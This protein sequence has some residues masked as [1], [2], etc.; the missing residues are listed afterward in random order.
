MVVPFLKF[1]LDS[2]THLLCLFFPHLEFSVLWEFSRDDTVQFQFNEHSWNVW[3]YIS[4][5]KLWSMNW[6]GVGV[7]L[8]ETNVT[9]NHVQFRKYVF[10]QFQFML[11]IQSV[12]IKS[13]FEG[14]PRF[15]ISTSFD[16]SFEIYRKMVVWL[17][18]INNHSNS[19]GVLKHL[20][21]EAATQVNYEVIWVFHVNFLG[22]IQFPDAPFMEYSPIHLL[23]IMLNVGESC[24]Y[25]EQ[26]GSR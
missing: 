5:R 15:L 19:T 20:S 23:L 14:L 9:M 7:V 17:T 24:I 6:A 8:R 13:P 2:T 12:S 3:M 4:G 22:C 21:L 1:R 25:V 11:W 18:R 26:L 16:T 10:K